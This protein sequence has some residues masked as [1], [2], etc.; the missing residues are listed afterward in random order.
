MIVIFAV[1]AVLFLLSIGYIVIV[2]TGPDD[3]SGKKKKKKSDANGDRTDHGG[4]SSA[5]GTGSAGGQG[6]G[7]KV[8]SPG[9]GRFSPNAKPVQRS[10]ESNYDFNQRMQKWATSRG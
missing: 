1:I 2:A 3:P 10:G 7:T 4:Q 8:I 5:G 9:A 6:P